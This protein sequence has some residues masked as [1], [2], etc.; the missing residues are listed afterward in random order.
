MN[1]TRSP[2]ACAN[3]PHI[4]K[5]RFKLYEFKCLLSGLCTA[6][7]V[8]TKAMKPVVSFLRKKGITMVICIDDILF[9]EKSD[10]ACRFN[11]EIAMSLH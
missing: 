4:S 2:F 10:R 6:P 7:Y 3:N 5:Y 1:H 8:F 11:P 9:I